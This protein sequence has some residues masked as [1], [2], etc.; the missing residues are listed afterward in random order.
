MSFLGLEDLEKR[1][2]KQAEAAVLISGAIDYKVH[3]Q[4]GGH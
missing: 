3:F 2:S 1:E 4:Q